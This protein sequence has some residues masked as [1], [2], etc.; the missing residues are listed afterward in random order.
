MGKA[1]REIR[2]SLDVKDTPITPKSSHK[3]KR[4]SG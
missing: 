2:K 4:V 1:A 3:K